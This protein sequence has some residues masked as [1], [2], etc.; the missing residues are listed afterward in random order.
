MMQFLTLMLKLALLTAFES[1]NGFTGDIS[2]LA[3]FGDR[4]DHSRRRRNTMH[5]EG[6]VTR[7]RCFP[8]ISYSNTVHPKLGAYTKLGA[9]KRP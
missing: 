5:V 8:L 9:Y 1:Y 3:L 6:K 7:T 4:S 2:R